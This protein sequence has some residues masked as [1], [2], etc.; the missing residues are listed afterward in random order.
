MKRSLP[1]LITLLLSS[2]ASEALSV[3]SPVVTPS[4][5]NQRSRELDGLT[6]TVYGYVI[7]E[8]E[9]YGVWDSRDAAK[10]RSAM[11]C[12]SLLY[13]Q[14]IRRQVAA[15]N[16]KMTYLRGVFMRDVTK[17]GGLYLGLCNFSGVL[18][19][20]INREAPQGE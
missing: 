19:E 17:E 5:L 10:S 7:H 15:A 8:R 14:E 12:V 3:R 1:F 4:E 9:A 13:P 11:K 16:R 2:C 6:V 18:V 20:S